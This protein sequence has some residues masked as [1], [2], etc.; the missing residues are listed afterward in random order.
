MKQIISTT[1]GLLIA[2][3]SVQAQAYWGSTNQRYKHRLT[4]A[5]TATAQPRNISIKGWRGETLNVQAVVENRQDE[6]L[7][8]FRLGK[9]VNKHKQTLRLQ[10]QEQGY[11]DEVL[12]DTFSACGTHPVEKYGRFREADRLVLKNYFLLPRNEQRGLWLSL[13]PSADSKPGIYSGQLEVLR[14][15]KVLQHLNLS[16]EV[17]AHRLPEAKD[18]RFHLDFWQ[19]PYAVARW[20]EVEPWSDKHFDLMRPYM[21][22][23]AASGQKVITATL[24]N[25]PWDGQ[26]EDPFGS[27]IQWTKRKDGSWSYDYNIFDRWVEFMMGCGID[28]EITCFSMIPWRLAFDYYDEA[29]ASIQKWESKPGEALYSERWGHFLQSFEKHLESKGWASKTTIAMDERSLEQMQA[30]IALIR[31][32]APK[33]K[34]SMAGNYHPEIESELVDYCVDYMSPGQYTPEVLARRKAEGK[35]ST[36]YTCCSSRILNTFTFSPLGEAELIPWYALKQGYDGY[37]RWA[38][39]SW[40]IDPNYDSRFRAWSAGDTYIVYPDN[41]PSLRWLKLQEGI[42]QFEK[43]RILMAEAKQSG[44]QARIQALQQILGLIQLGRIDQVGTMVDELEIALNKL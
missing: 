37:L 29:T 7:Y 27:M 4:N 38:Y 15:G 8:S 9:L 14:S 2:L 43:Y 41:Y 32:S 3:G 39:N 19:N 12:A 13:Q 42:Q 34:I 6:A 20:H 1:L 10:A 22:R 17:L 16:V 24:I 25:R 31:K 5:T 18:W 23:L 11:V 33:I 40:T 21:Q 26:T 36:Y 30:A 44:N 28:K 35:I